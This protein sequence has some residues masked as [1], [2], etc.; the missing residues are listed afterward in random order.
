MKIE[1]EESWKFVSPLP[2]YICIHERILDRH[3]D[4]MGYGLL[5]SSIG[6]RFDRYY[7]RRFISFYSSN[8]PRTSGL[9]RVPSI[10]KLFPLGIPLLF[11]RFLHVSLLY[12]S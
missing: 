12:N 2:L 4:R 8:L 7:I 6:I 9:L 1:I 3:D 10:E 5:I 11:R